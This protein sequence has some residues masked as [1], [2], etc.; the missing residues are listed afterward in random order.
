[1][2]QTNI[3]I[4]YADVIILYIYT[5]IVNQFSLFTVMEMLTDTCPR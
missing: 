3:E 4:D 5:L 1:M 2:P